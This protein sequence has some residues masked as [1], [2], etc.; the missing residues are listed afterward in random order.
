VITHQQ[1]TI[2]SIGEPLC[3]VSAFK[4]KGSAQVTGK[5]QD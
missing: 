2:C 5:V 1:I 4:E 3:F